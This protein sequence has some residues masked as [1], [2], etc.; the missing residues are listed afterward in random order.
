MGGCPPPT[1]HT[2]ALLLLLLCCLA[3]A[4]SAAR[5]CGIAELFEE[6]PQWVALP[7]AA[8][9]PDA[10]AKALELVASDWDAALCALAPE[11]A[12][13]A[14]VAACQSTE[15][16]HVKKLG[17]SGTRRTLERTGHVWPPCEGRRSAAC[18]PTSASSCLAFPPLLHYLSLQ[19]T[20]VQAVLLDVAIP[21]LEPRGE[22]VL[23][24][25]QV[26]VRIAQDG[27]PAIL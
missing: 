22:T 2:L 5:P 9:A 16:G 11:R 7:A 3:A 20:G 26:V 8:V 13:A 12:Q 19:A 17:S 23:V 27:A 14:V 15:V 24:A 25:G 4:A 21:C 18:L 1:I 10:A 6:G